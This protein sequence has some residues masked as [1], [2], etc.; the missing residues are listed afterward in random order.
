MWQSAWVA[1]LFKHLSFTQVMILGSWD[2]V[3]HRAPFSVG[4]LLLPHPL[5][6]TL[7]SLMFSLPQKNK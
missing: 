7:V 6:L 1:Q 5:S 3:L 2:G 4:T